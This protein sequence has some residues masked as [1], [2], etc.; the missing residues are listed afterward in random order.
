MGEKKLKVSNYAAAFIDV[1]GQ[2]DSMK[3]CGLVPDNKD[4]FLSIAKKSIGVISNLHSSFDTFYELLTKT[5]INL[6][7]PEEDRDKYSHLQAAKLK[8]QRFSDGL[9]VFISLAEDS[10]HSPVNGIY[11]LIASSGSLC[12]LGLAE[13]TPI[14]GGADIAWGVELNE[15][16]LYGCVVAKSYELESEVAKYPRIIIG[17]EI[18][19]YLQS[20]AHN[21]EGD[22]NSQYGRKMAETCIEMVCETPDGNY[23]VDYLGEGFRKY[24]ANTLDQTIYNEALSYVEEQ[25]ERWRDECN[26]KLIERYETLHEYFVE[27]KNVWAS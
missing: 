9:V 6:Q 24:I 4:E 23:M 27:R 1:L 8:F 3:G 22:I 21:E 5:T 7:I 19:N 20:L 16:E 17:S 11:G 14:R 18:I 10:T 26:S 25:L 2:R 13:K 15:S 12:L